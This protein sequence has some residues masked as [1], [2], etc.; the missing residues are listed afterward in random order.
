MAQIR[1]FRA[2]RYNPAV[3]GD[4]KNV[5]SPPYD[6]IS[7]QQQ[8]LLHLQSPYNATHLDFNKADDPYTGSSPD[9]SD[10]AVSGGRA[11]RPA[12]GLLLLYA[13]VS[14]SRTASH[15]AG[16]VFLPRYGLKISSPES[17]ART[18]APLSGPKKIVSPCCAPAGRT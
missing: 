5:V 18:S 16:P 13:G 8:T 11:A 6:V 2:L 9:F 10:L 4:L 7:P 3:V 15:G 14:P 12:A 17:F 1:P